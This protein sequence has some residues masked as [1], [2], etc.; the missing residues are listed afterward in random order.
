MKSAFQIF[1]SLEQVLLQLMV[2]KLTSNIYLIF[3]VKYKYGL[4]TKTGL[5]TWTLSNYPK[6]NK[7][8]ANQVM[9]CSI[10]HLWLPLPIHQLPNAVST[11]K[12]IPVFT[13]LQAEK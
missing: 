13:V 10:H 4:N 7:K 11:Q 9:K 3:L 5:I 12:S 2:I 8:L 6:N 1:V